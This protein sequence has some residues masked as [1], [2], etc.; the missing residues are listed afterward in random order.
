M[1]RHQFFQRIG[2]VRAGLRRTAREAHGGIVRQRQVIVRTRKKGAVRFPVVGNAAHRNPAE[3]HA[4]I[5]LLAADQAKARA[6]PA[7]LEIRACQL[8]RGV[9]RF[10]SRID[11]EHMIEA[12][13]RERCNTFGEFERG[14]MSELEGGREIERLRRLRN[15]ARDFLAAMARVHAPQSRTG[16]EQRAALLIVEI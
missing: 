11:E 13:R 5:G 9:G 12:G 10:R 7:F 6:L 14:W 8:E 2:I 4:V 16:I 15:R 1:Q 3:R